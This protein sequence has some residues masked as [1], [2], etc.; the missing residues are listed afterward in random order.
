M[1]SKGRHY[2]IDET[3]AIVKFIFPLGQAYESEDVNYNLEIFDRKKVDD[4]NSDDKEIS[5]VRFLFKNL[6]VKAIL[7]LVNGEDEIWMIESG[8]NKSKL[9]IWRNKT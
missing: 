9:Y 1:L 5:K 3:T 4:E 8:L 2:L 7:E 6:F